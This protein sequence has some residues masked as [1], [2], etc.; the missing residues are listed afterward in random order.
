[1]R[2]TPQAGSR[3]DPDI[4][5]RPLP[6]WPEATPEIARGRDEVMRLFAQIREPW[7]ATDVLEVLGDFVT[8]GDRVIARYRWKAEGHGPPMSMELTYANTVRKQTDR[9]DRDVLGPR[10][11]PRSLRT[12]GVRVD[13][14]RDS[15]RDSG[16]LVSP[17]SPSSC[18]ARL[19]GRYWVAHGERTVCAHPTA[20]PSLVRSHV[21]SAASPALPLARRYAPLAARPT[22]A[23]VATPADRSSA[24]RETRDRGVQSPRFRGGTSWPPHR[25]RVPTSERDD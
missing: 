18:P 5:V 23:H 21:R 12:I 20:A 22:A 14:E 9:R 11:D 17:P 15:S 7:N 10:Q 13:A 2:D 1:M 8:A 4:V 6:D 25:L 3:Y 19:R 16:V 24:C